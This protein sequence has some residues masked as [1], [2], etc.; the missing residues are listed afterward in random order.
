MSDNIND[1]VE[2]YIKLRETKAVAKKAFEKKLAPVNSAMAEIEG[3]LLANMQQLGVDSFKT[4]GGTAYKSRRTSAKMED[5]DVFFQYVL[6]NGAS[7][8]LERRASKAA[9]E[10]FRDA[11]DELPP[12]VGWSEEVTVNFRKT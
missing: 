4:E 3:K 5:W 11:H 12:G 1:L 10:E 2:L 7:E 6:D 9:V 8:L